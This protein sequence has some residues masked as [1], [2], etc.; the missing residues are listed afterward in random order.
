MEGIPTD[1]IPVSDGTKAIIDGAV[2]RLTCITLREQDAR[3]DGRFACERSFENIERPSSKVPP[4]SGIYGTL[5]I[6]T[7]HF[8]QC[9]HPL[10]DLPRVDRLSSGSGKLV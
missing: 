3:F 8:R 10:K 7:G 2:K 5:P 4:A 6:R 1:R 9:R